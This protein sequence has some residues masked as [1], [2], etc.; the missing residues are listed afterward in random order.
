MLYKEQNMLLTEAN[1]AR[2]H[3]YEMVQ[4]ERRHKVRKSMGAIRHVLGE[5]K[6]KKIAEHRAYLEKLEQVEKL[7]A[8]MGKVRIEGGG[9][10]DALDNEATTLTTKEL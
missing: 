1:L 9:I 2:R 7:M 3:G 8:K 5:R 10:E 6:R 4:P